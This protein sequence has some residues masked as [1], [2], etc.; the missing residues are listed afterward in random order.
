MPSAQPTGVP[1][2]RLTTIVGPSPKDRRRINKFKC[3]DALKNA[4]MRERV[5]ALVGMRFK[6]VFFA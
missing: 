2:A 1:S 6:N 4:L 3:G 5:N